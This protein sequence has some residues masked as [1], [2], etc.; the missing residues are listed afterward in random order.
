MPDLQ[1]PDLQHFPSF[2][3]QAEAVLEHF[4]QHEL[5]VV[6]EQE[7]TAKAPMEAKIMNTFFI[8]VMILTLIRSFDL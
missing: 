7:E 4:P 6:D 2:P 1:L 8:N 3:Q 5:A